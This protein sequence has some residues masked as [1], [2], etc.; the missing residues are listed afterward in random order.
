MASLTITERSEQMPRNTART[1]FN[2]NYEQALKANFQY[3]LWLPSYLGHSLGLSHSPV[4]DSIM[5]PFY[6]VRYFI[7]FYRRNA[8]CSNFCFFMLI[9]FRARRRILPWHMTT[10]W[11]CISCTVSR[12]CTIK[13]NPILQQSP[14]IY[15]TE[16]LGINI[17]CCL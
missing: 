13:S 16:K 12:L 1:T 17:F 10:F 3:F 2:K 5:Y 9:L 7:Y 8:K 14:F 6:K 4:A 15:H 11:P